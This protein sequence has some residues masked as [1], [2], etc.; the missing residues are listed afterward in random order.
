MNQ[1]QVLVAGDVCPAR[2]VGDDLLTRLR[3]TESPA[4]FIF[5]LDAALPSKSP[6]PQFTCIPFAAEDL[7]ALAIGKSNLAVIASNHLTDFGEAGVEQTLDELT[8]RGF[9]YTGGGLN[10]QQARQ[11]ASLK[12]ESGRVAVLAYAE[13][14]PRVGALAATENRGGVRA[15]DLEM[16][17]QEV[18]E[19]RSQSDWV[20]VILH[21]GEEFVRYPDPEQRRMA[22]RL[23]DAG[24]SLVVAS[25]THVPLG[26]E[27][28]GASSIFYG[29]GNFLYP[30]Y[31]EA[32]G[33]RYSWHASAR[34][35][36]VLA[37]NFQDG[38]WNWQPREIRLS[39]AG[40]PRL[41]AHR[42]CPDYGQ[43]LPNDLAGYEES[44]PTLRAR[45]RRT[46]LVQRLLS[47]SWQERVFRL[48]QLL[49][50][51]ASSAE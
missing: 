33:Y 7:N 36:V 23:V 34:D 17:T 42:H 13:T 21:W 11:N 30:P 40:L 10:R 2:I 38:V 24:A 44:F 37:G 5:T 3:L 22:W 35:G 50:L 31:R 41:H 15:F 14:S 26:F 39:A 32:R 19:A 43:R 27:K 45:E 4:W 47:M 18:E 16:C 12:F 49:G 28:R 20:W 8:R 51:K 9:H 46:F 6:R 25:H 48:R 1:P 29:L